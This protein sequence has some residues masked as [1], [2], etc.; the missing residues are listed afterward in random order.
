[1]KG[2]LGKKAL[3]GVREI[4]KNYISFHVSSLSASWKQ[5]LIHFASWYNISSLY[6]VLIQINKNSVQHFRKQRRRNDE[7]EALEKRLRKP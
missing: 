7:K 1:M 4:N 3:H 6:V 2:K 5:F